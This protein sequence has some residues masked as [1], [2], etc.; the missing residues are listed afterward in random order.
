MPRSPAGAAF[1]RVPSLSEASRQRIRP[2]PHTRARLLVP[3]RFRPPRAAPA[4]RP[5]LPHRRSNPAPAGQRRPLP[6]APPARTPPPNRRAAP[7]ATQTSKPLR[8]G[9]TTGCAAATNPNQPKLR[10]P[11]AR[12]RNRNPSP[13]NVTPKA[14]PKYTNP[15][16][17]RRRAARLPGGAA[18]PQHRGLLVEPPGARLRA[19]AGPGAGGGLA[20]DPGALAG[21]SRPAEPKPPIP[22][23]GRRPLR[24][25]RPASATAPRRG[26]SLAVGAALVHCP[27]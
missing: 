22:R 15:N 24:R 23:R 9:N 18:P 26:P 13:Q 14:K 5:A 20:A 25:P 11:T 19:H 17:T 6:P 27:P 7:R 8:A 10:K 21:R 16:P 3:S 1:S 4:S 12:N 2:A